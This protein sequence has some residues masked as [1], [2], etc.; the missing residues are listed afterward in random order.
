[1]IRWPGK[2]K[3][4]TVSNEL[5]SSLDWAPTLV[6]AAGDPELKEKL[7]KGYSATGKNFNSTSTASTSYRF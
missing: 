7:L 5:F 3:P 6:A 2:I 4:G 1:M